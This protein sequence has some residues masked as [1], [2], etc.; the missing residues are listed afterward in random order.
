[1]SALD[2]QVGGGHYRNKAI[3]PVQ[4]SMA[5]GLDA[6][7]HSVVKYVTRHREKNGRQDL[8]KAIHFI[9]LRLQLAPP[10]V[11]QE[12]W[13]ICPEDYCRLNKLAVLETAVIIGLGLWTTTGGAHFATE[14]KEVIS[15]IISAN[16][17]STGE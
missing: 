11:R 15:Q 13:V 1:M 2:T 3:Q 9:D 16:Y 17:D 4:F 7:A 5:N 8:E 14:M 6:C 12:P 10:A